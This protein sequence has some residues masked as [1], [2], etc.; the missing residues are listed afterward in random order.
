MLSSFSK[1]YCKACSEREV[2]TSLLVEQYYQYKHKPEEEQIEVKNQFAKEIEAAYPYKP[3]RE[4]K[5][6]NSP[7]KE[8]DYIREDNGL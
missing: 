6:S 7:A 2:P 3:G 4:P 5:Q 8:Y 1:A